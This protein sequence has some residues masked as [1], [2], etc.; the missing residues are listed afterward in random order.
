[1]KLILLIIFSIAGL[2]GCG[3]AGGGGGDGSSEGS[4]G[5]EDTCFDCDASQAS[6]LHLDS[7]GIGAFLSVD[8][9]TIESSAL[10]ALKS[11]AG[12]ETT[13][14]PI[15]GLDEEDGEI[16]DALRCFTAETE[17]AFDPD[18][19][20]G[21]S[22]DCW[23]PIPRIVTVAECGGL[24]YLVFE[25]PF[26]VRT[27]TPD[28]LSLEDY[29]DPWSPSS[30][31]TSQLLRSSQPIT[32]YQAGDR[33]ERTNLEGVLYSLEINTWDRRRNI[34]FDGSCNLYVTAH[35]PGT[36]RDVLIRIEPDA[37]EDEYTEIINA[38]ICYER[39]LVNSNGDVHYT[40]R[41][42][43]GSDC[44]GDSFYRVVSNEG[45]LTEIT[46]GWWDYEF[47]PRDDGTVVFYGPD[48]TQDG[49]PSWDNACLFEFDGAKSGDARYS[50]K[51]NCINDWWR[52][53]SEGPSSEFRTAAN[54][55][56][57][58]RCTEQFYTY[59]GSNAPDKILSIDRNGDGTEEICVVADTEYKKAGTW[60][61]DI[62]VDANTGH[63]ENSSGVITGDI[64]QSACTATTGNSWSTTSKCYNDVATTACTI[65]QPSG[66]RLNH[67]WCQDPGS[68][69]SLTYSALSCI[70]SDK[71]VE[72][73]S[74]ISETVTNSWVTGSRLIYSAVGDSEYHLKAVTF[75]P[76]GA[77]SVSD[78]I[79]G[80]EVYEVAVDPTEGVDR[81]LVNGLRFSDNSYVFGAYD[82]DE[83]ALQVDTGLTGLIETMLV[84]GD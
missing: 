63:C 17:E 80:V 51:V 33:L 2:S 66:W 24:I 12:E 29:S 71:S 65:T 78:L 54:D 28:G 84:V 52:Y 79:S 15:Q 21:L 76:S 35:V 62:C 39:Y 20:A 30:P 31:F 45:V 8:P 56:E 48:P 36:S 64:S 59:R 46:R 68:S 61:C 3:G 18:S 58:E 23:D 7:E 19:S 47:E 83:G 38:N 43:V 81:I 1:M 67:D 37:G 10:S 13:P 55:T 74:G 82:F 77:A 72:L 49:V 50:R 34:Q 40:G 4:G 75:N 32:D 6:F 14:S 60:K 44:G 5:G 26:I 69:W 73:I 57:R 53:V 11:Q 9:D 70:K 41:T 42:S 25:R 22:A 16:R 27:E